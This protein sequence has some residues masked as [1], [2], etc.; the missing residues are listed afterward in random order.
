MANGLPRAEF[1]K[2]F[3]ADRCEYPAADRLRAQLSEAEFSAFCDCGCNSFAVKPTRG[4]PVL[5][6][7]DGEVGHRAIYTADFRLADERTLEIILFADGGGNLD[8]I[9]VDCCANSEPVPDTVEV[10]AQPFHTWAT[11]QLLT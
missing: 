9:E 3:V 7:P 2:G 11:E 1:W 4:A 10:D 8:Y 5:V 6:A